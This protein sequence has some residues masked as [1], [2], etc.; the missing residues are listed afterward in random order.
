[1]IPIAVITTVATRED[2]VR[3]GR[4]LVEQRLAACAQIEPIESIYR[5]KGELHQEPEFRLV[6]KTSDTRYSD[7]ERA[8]A[9]MHPYELPAIHALPIAH[10]H[11]PYAEWLQA[12]TEA[13]SPAPAK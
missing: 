5:W 3:I 12:N 11:A 4:A 2:A 8:I 9:E 10:I 7:I 13:A 6:L 1:M